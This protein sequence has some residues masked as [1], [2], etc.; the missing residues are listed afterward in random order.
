MSLFKTKPQPPAEPVVGLP[1]PG[2]LITLVV[3]VTNNGAINIQY[4]GEP[5]WAI[6]TLRSLADQVEVETSEPAQP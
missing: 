1:D 4:L 6:Q 2:D 5:A 3:K